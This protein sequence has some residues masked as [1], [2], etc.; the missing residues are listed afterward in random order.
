MITPLPVG[1][2]TPRPAAGRV[3]GEGEALVPVGQHLAN[4]RRKGALGKDP[5]R[6][7]T[8]AAQ[9]TAIAPDWNCPFGGCQIEGVTN[10]ETC[11]N[12]GQPPGR[13]CLV[14]GKIRCVTS[15]RRYA[16]HALGHVPV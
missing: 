1:H 15:W 9:L 6:A 7:E 3:W 2:R 4:L 10:V 5:E 11:R 14:N 13:D 8:R 16:P 12:G